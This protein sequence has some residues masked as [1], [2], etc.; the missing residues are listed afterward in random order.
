[1][2]RFRKRHCPDRLGQEKIRLSPR[3]MKLNENT[4]GKLRESQLHK[5]AQ[6]ILCGRNAETAFWGTEI[7][8]EI[9]AVGSLLAGG[10]PDVV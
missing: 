1:M 8:V 9:C 10:I 5:H 4:S 6:R 7:S 3:M 2:A